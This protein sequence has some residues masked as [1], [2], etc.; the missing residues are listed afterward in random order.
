MKM[1]KR[2]LRAALAATVVSFGVSGVVVAQGVA[3]DAGAGANVGV[4]AGA[5]AGGVGVEAG[6]GGNVGAGIGGGQIRGGE[7]PI[8]PAPGN[9]EVNLNQ[10]A[11]ATGAVRMIDKDKREVT[12]DN[13]Q[14][15]K[16]ATNV[17][18]ANVAQGQRYTFQYN[19]E[20]TERLVIKIDPPL[21]GGAR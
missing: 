17:D 13:G 5:G 8:N 9:P 12:L 18:L 19:L 11:N 21:E 3:P 4:G 20:G 16:I 2:V 7:A 15:Y 1:N 14:T 10:V 6:A